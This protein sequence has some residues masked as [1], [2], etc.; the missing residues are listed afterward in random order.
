LIFRGEYGGGWL[1]LMAW[2]LW[3][4]SGEAYHSMVAREL[5]KSITVREIMRAPLQR[6]SEALNLRELAE[7]FASWLRPPALAVDLDGSAVGMIGIAQVNKI[8]RSQWQ[9]TRVRQAM[10]P[11]ADTTVVAP[12]DSALYALKLLTE[13]DRDDMPVMHEGQVIGSIGRDELARYLKAKGE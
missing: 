3:R 1:L 13:S 10:I 2:F 11:L 5:L 6:V 4:A 9:A 7:S 8:S 12:H